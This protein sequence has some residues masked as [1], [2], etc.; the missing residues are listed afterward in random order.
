MAKVNPAILTW[1]RETAGLSLDQ[2][3]IAIKLKDAHGRKAADR[4]FA[5]EKGEEEPTRPLLLRM[6]EKYR[7]PLIAFYLDKPPRQGD[8]GQDFRR[9][10]GSALPEYNPTLDALIRDINAR[11]GIVKSLLEDEEASPLPF[12]GSAN[13]D[14]GIESIA[15]QI[16]RTV[17]FA[18]QEYRSQK[19]IDDAFGYLR[20]KLEQAGIFV[21]LMGNL[22]THHTNIP[23]ETFRGFSFAD[24]IAPFIVINDQDA[25]SAWSFTA[26]H[27]AAHLWLG[28]TGISGASPRLPIER[29]CNEVAAS[30]LLP[31]AEIQ[32]LSDIPAL[33]LDGATDRISVFSEE[34]K[35]SR[36]MVSYRLFRANIITEPKWK[37]LEEHF[38][39]QWLDAEA[40]RKKPRDEGK[41]G[42]PNYYVV[43]EHRLGPALVNLAARALD[44]GALTYTKAARVLGVKPLS[45]QPLLSGVFERGGL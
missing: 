43:R 17:G 36:T 23:A 3:A 29:F 28:E 14:Q 4:L 45:V 38:H 34:R 12:I 22:G 11:Q 35:I 13:R 44:E 24:P 41:K 8:R 16:T 26:L 32:A 40:R 20:A 6:A 31:C 30:L 7:R 5:M 10:S 19:S 2:A 18:L 21:V 37:R 15:E 33:T 42:G 9:T 25:R 1:A 39:K 27:E